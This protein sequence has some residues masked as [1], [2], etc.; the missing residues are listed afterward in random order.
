MYIY[1]YMYMY[2]YLWSADILA[3]WWGL[4]HNFRTFLWYPANSSWSW[5]WPK[6]RNQATIPLL[7]TY[8]RLSC[9]Q[10]ADHKPSTKSERRKS[11]LSLCILYVNQF[12]LKNS[13]EISLQLPPQSHTHARNMKYE[14]FKSPFFNGG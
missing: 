11:K 9:F 13:F 5:L 7:L 1:L 3:R 2:I 10:C 14:P 8:W 6:S 12:F 4:K